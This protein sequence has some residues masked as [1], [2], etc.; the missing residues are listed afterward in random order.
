MKSQVLGYQ[1][2]GFRNHINIIKYASHQTKNKQPCT[3]QHAAFSPTT[4][5]HVRKVKSKQN[6]SPENQLPVPLLRVW[7]E[8]QFK[9]ILDDP[10]FFWPS[11]CKSFF[12]CSHK[13]RGKVNAWSKWPILPSCKSEIFTTRSRNVLISLKQAVRILYKEGVK[14]INYECAQH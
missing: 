8:R 11:R 14:L 1:L 3:Q 13:P 10:D 5:H 2:Q 6:S 7:W 9:N 4:T 12:S